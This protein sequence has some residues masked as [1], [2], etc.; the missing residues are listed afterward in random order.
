MWEKG[1][2]GKG[3]NG[4]RVNCEKGKIGKGENWKGKYGK[5]AKR[6]K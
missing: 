5:M 4:K 6:G 3:G 2:K 1:Y